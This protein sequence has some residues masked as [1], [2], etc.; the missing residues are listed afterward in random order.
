MDGVI[1][2]ARVTAGNTSSQGGG[3]IGVDIFV[4]V[5]ADVDGT[6]V[7]FV[8]CMP[9]ATAP[10]TTTATVVRIFASSV[11]AGVTTPANTFLLAEAV[12]PASPADNAATAVTPIDIPLNFRLPNGWSLLATNHVAPAANTVWLSVAI[13]GNY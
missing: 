4:I 8:R 9:T 5:I 3:T 13:G 12:L 10:T 2:A 11:V 1:G 6:L 7:E